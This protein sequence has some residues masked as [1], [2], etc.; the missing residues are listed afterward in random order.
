MRRLELQAKAELLSRRLHSYVR[1]AW[2][3][4]EPETPFVDGWCLG[5]ICE[6]LQAVDQGQIRNL[7]INIPPRHTKSITVSVL[8]PTFRWTKFPGEQFLFASYGEALALRDSTKSRR[9]IKSPW[10][11]ERWGKNFILSS[12]QDT[13]GFYTNS[14]GGHRFSTSVDATTTGFGGDVLCLDDPHNVQE[15][16]SELVRA[17]TIKY[18]DEAWSTRG[19]NPKTVK[20]VCIMQRVH[21]GDVS[22]HLLKK[23]NWVHLVLPA[24]YSGKA[25]S[26]ARGE[27]PVP[28]P[29]GWKDPRKAEGELLWP[30]RMGPAEIKDA[31]LTGVRAYAGQYQ[32]EPTAA[33]GDMFR[34]DI[35]KAHIVKSMREMAWYEDNMAVITGRGWDLAAT[36]K[37]YSKRTAGVKMSQDEHKRF[38][39]HHVS[40]GKYRPDERNAEMMKVMNADGTIKQIIEH[41]QGSAGEDQALALTRLFVGHRV[42][43]VPA[44]G[45]KAVRADQFAAQVNAGNVWLIDDGT[46]DVELYLA[47]LQS[48]PNGDYSDQVDGSSHMFNWLRPRVPERPRPRKR[49]VVSELDKLLPS[50]AGW[51]D[52]LG[53]SGL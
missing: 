10:Y 35:L 45:D 51:Q 5:A 15:A 40:A 37:K 48:F 46:W 49:E 22:S 52:K 20:K 4:L 24:E 32:Q 53:G 25:F 33:G 19:N 16:E 26:Y 14:R 23:G 39:I 21:T 18:V 3:I 41:E 11:Q 29:L 12:D 1:E 38:I 47:E 50:T 30:E 43:F 36:I 2:H 31:Q 34:V 44:S 27:K 8:W 7:L 28:N 9:V 17:A 42:E 6:H 13:K